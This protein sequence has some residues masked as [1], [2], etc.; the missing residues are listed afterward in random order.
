[1]VERRRNRFS[2]VRWVH[3]FM[4][5]QQTLSSIVDRMEFD[6]LWEPSQQGFT[7][8]EEPLNIFVM[9]GG[10]MKGFAHQVMMEELL[11]MAGEKRELFGKATQLTSR[12]QHCMHSHAFLFS[13]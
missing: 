4:N 7:I 12:I 11:N 5:R 10:G 9:G 3:Q 2:T 1:M 8:E 6:R 13:F